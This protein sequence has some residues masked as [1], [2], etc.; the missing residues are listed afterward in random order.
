[1]AIEN[2]DLKAAGSSGKEMKD[3]RRPEEESE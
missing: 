3:A 2:K 1:M